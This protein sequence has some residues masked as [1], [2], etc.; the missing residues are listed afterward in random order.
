MSYKQSLLKNDTNLI[1]HFPSNV[2]YYIYLYFVVKLRNNATCTLF[3]C[4]TSS[5]NTSFSLLACPGGKERGHGEAAGALAKCVV[6]PA[7]TGALVR[8]RLA[9]SGV[10]GECG[11]RCRGCRGRR[12]R[13]QAGSPAGACRREAAASAGSTPCL[14][15]SPPPSPTD[16]AESAGACAAFRPLM[17]GKLSTWLH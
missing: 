7:V 1:T 4:F 10:T 11:D 13:R 16:S 12:E 15:N 2:T 17:R 9:G 3:H 5:P 6:T 14:H 8:S